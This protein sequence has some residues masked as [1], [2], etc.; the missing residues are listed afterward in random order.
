MANVKLC[1]KTRIFQGVEEAV[2]FLLKSVLLPVVDQ[3]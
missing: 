3:H 1:H 2:E